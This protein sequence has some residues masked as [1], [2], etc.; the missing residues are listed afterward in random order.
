[1]QPNDKL[2]EAVSKQ[3]EKLSSFSQLLGHLIEN[4]KRVN[5][6]MERMYAILALTV[7]TGGGALGALLGVFDKSKQRSGGTVSISQDGHLTVGEDFAE[8]LQTSITFAQLRKDKIRDNEILL[9]QRKEQIRL[10]ELMAATY[11]KTKQAALG[12]GATT[13]AEQ[14]AARYAAVAT[15]EGG[16]KLLSLDFEYLKDKNNNPIATSVA[17]QLQEPGKEPRTMHLFFKDILGGK[18]GPELEEHLK[19]LG[20]TSTELQT[21][22]LNYHTMQFPEFLQ[23]LRGGIAK[24]DLPQ[25][26]A[27]FLGTSVE[28]LPAALRSV[29]MSAYANTHG[30]PGDL[31]LLRSHLTREVEVPIDPTK[32][33][34]GTQKTTVSHYD[35]GV[36]FDPLNHPLVQQLT[37]D[38]NIPRD[39]SSV[40]TA[41]FGQ[42]SHDLLSQAVL[43]PGKI[44][45]AKMHHRAD[46]DALMNALIAYKIIQ[47][48]K[49]GQ[50]LDPGLLHPEVAQRMAQLA[51][52]GSPAAPEATGTGPAATPPVAATPGNDSAPA[53]PSGPATDLPSTPAPGPGESKGKGQTKAA[54]QSTVG[55]RRLAI[56]AGAAA[57]ILSSIAKTGSPDA[58][59]TLMDSLKLLTARISGLV[60]PTFVTMAVKLQKAAKFFEEHQEE[61]NGLGEN[62]GSTLGNVLSGPGLAGAGLGGAIGGPWGAAL[63]ALGGATLNSFLSAKEEADQKEKQEQRLADTNL[64]KVSKIEDIQ[65]RSLAITQFKQI[66][67]SGHNKYLF[68]QRNFSSENA[69]LSREI[70]K[71]LDLNKYRVNWDFEKGTFSIQ[72]PNLAESLDADRQKKVDSL[73]SIVSARTTPQFSSVEDTYRRVQIEALGKGPIEQ[74]LEETNTKWLKS[75]LEKLTVIADKEPPKPVGSR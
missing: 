55:L 51:A 22:G 72:G 65:D 30:D 44:R 47:G 6:G 53:G 67:S 27:N 18:S 45:S 15:Q 11:E 28:N 71:I 17:M 3:A 49:I 26:L 34:L 25:H 19:S 68:G 75:M 56:A 31:N 23:A 10:E 5:S 38:Q 48:G 73:F 69:D 60:I 43:G 40:F 24:G 61:I 54:E 39:L 52:G 16:R 2:S 64:D 66:L 8:Q 57:G 62:I 58:V 50:A 4:I 63:G 70:G 9:Q 29:T 13:P 74:L 37:K 33:E 14:E 35:E 46:L 41:F 7:G 42:E 59:A 1:M 32:P 21:H 12:K 36:V 20:L